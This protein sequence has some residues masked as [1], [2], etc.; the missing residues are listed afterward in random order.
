M[1]PL[2]TDCKPDTPELSTFPC[3]TAIEAYVSLCTKLKDLVKSHL[4]EHLKKS[5]DEEDVAYVKRCLDANMCLGDLET[6]SANLDP[7]KSDEERMAACDYIILKYS[8]SKSGGQPVAN[9][10]FKTEIEIKIGGESQAYGSL[11]N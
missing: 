8:A 6:S 7:T 1:C 11:R 9:M 2:E 5:E 3:A 10:H 4:E